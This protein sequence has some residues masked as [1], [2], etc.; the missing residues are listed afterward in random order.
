MCSQAQNNK[1]KTKTKQKQMKGIQ[2]NITK[3]K[4]INKHFNVNKKCRIKT[5]SQKKNK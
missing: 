1:T 3:K 5:K 2:I 4:M